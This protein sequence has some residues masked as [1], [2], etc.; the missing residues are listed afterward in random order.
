[1]GMG[2]GVYVYFSGY[3]PATATIS[4]KVDNLSDTLV[5]VGEAYGGCQLGGFCPSFQVADDGS[6]RYFYMPTGA[7]EQV[8][9]EGEIPN[10]LH[11]QL[12][13]VLTATELQ[14]S[15]RRI[16]PAMCESYVDGIDVTY[17][18][19]LNETDYELDSCGTDVNGEGA[20]WQTLG[21][22]WNYFETVS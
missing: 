1:M 21:Q 6:Y 11:A 20:M 5:V 10:D 12:R 17:R 8:L 13:R 4:E 19:T 22:V 15:S 16:E 9:R 14:V 3:A 2:I 7:S 18:V